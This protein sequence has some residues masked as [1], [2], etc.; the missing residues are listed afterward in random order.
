MALIEDS[1]IALG[2]RILIGVSL[3]A[4]ANERIDDIL[5]AFAV[6]IDPFIEDDRPIEICLIEESDTMREH[7]DNKSARVLWIKQTED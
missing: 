5:S 2:N 3:D 7:I 6:S 4:E 1:S